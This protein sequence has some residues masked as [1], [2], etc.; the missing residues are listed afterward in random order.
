MHSIDKTRQVRRTSPDNRSLFHFANRASVSLRT[1]KHVFHSFGIFTIAAI[2]PVSKGGKASC[3]PNDHDG[4]MITDSWYLGAFGRWWRGGPFDAW[5]QDV[6]ARSNDEESWSSGILA[7]KGPE[8]HGTCLAL[9][10]CIVL[11]NFRSST[12]DEQ[13]RRSTRTCT[14]RPA[15]VTKPR[16]PISAKQP[17]IS[18]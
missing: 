13:A 8:R 5:Y 3:I 11:D 15:Q 12:F 9:L 4:S 10:P 1:P 7:I 16:S 18:A 14:R 17:A 6:V 2:L